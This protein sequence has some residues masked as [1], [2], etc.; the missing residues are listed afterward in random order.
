MAVHP[1]IP[2]NLDSNAESSVTTWYVPVGP[3]LRRVN[4]YHDFSE[5]CFGMDYD[6][7][8]R[9]TLQEEATTCSQCLLD[10]WSTSSNNP[11]AEKKFQFGDVSFTVVLETMHT[12]FV[13][14][15]K[16][17]DLPFKV[18]QE[19]YNRQYTTWIV[20]IKNQQWRIVFEIAT[21]KLFVNGTTFN[22]IEGNF[23]KDGGIAK[24]E[25]N[26]NK[27]RI[28]TQLEKR[29]RISEVSRTLFLFDEFIPSTEVH[30]ES[31][32]R[33]NAE[34]YLRM[35]RSGLFWPST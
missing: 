9:I 30:E 29:G 26:Q 19:E 23:K 35:S 6:G 4:L 13:Y 25:L 8:N 2:P 20:K 3:K 14:T 15:L 21:E 28:E 32:H 22:D 33:Q 17:N 24:F 10:W 5:Y 31:T 16:V 1:Y 34:R 12:E 27:F 18:F 7:S 11:S